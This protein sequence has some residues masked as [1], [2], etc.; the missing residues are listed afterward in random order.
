M[1]VEYR[2]YTAV[3]YGKSSLS[4]YRP[5]GTE[6]MHTGSRN[7]EYTETEDGLKELINDQIDLFESGKFDN[8]FKDNN[9]DD[10][11]I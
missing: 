8:I 9:T 1:K 7:K 5:D 4:I 3:T 6:C 10:D 11:D 2:G